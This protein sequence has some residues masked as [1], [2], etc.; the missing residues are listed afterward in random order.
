MLP[1]TVNWQS[2]SDGESFGKTMLATANIQ[3]EVGK[4][5]L[6]KYTGMLEEFSMEE[7]RSDPRA[8]HVDSFTSPQDAM[9]SSTN[10]SKMLVISSFSTSS[11]TERI[12]S[13]LCFSQSSQTLRPISPIS[14]PFQIDIKS[15]SLLLAEVDK[16]G[17]EF[18]SRVFVQVFGNNY[19][20]HAQIY[21]DPSFCIQ[22]GYISLRNC[23]IEIDSADSRV[24]Y[25]ELGDVLDT[26]VSRKKV[27]LT[28][29][30]EDIALEWVEAL[31]PRTKLP[32]HSDSSPTA[33]PLQTRRFFDS[34]CL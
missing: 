9:Q 16:D 14:P 8:T 28:A 7:H 18:T 26:N 2:G 20:Q 13:D 10:F 17:H 29:E 27:K 1:C 23:H 25:I 30:T 24:I 15:G 19:E 6:S 12:S 3:T 22:L 4:S 5:D 32:I 34:T 33:T 31:T 21:T 11:P